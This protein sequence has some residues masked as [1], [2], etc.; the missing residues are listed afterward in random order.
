MTDG[1]H[2]GWKNGVGSQK[3]DPRRRDLSN[4]LPFSSVYRSML[5]QKQTMK[6]DSKQ[7]GREL[8]RDEEDSE[9]KEV[10]EVIRKVVQ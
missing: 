4:V 10:A 9:G 3:F 6:K 2:Q 1:R 5:N 7:R 8:T